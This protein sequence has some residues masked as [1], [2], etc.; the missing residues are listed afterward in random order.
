LGNEHPQV[1][2]FRAPETGPPDRR[3]P[4]SRLA[5]E[6]DRAR[7]LGLVGE[8]CEQIVELARSAEDRPAHARTLSA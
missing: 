1:A 5:A 2:L 6:N 4:D 3:L 8:E 7:R